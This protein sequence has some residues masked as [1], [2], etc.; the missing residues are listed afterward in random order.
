M[1]HLKLQDAFLC[2]DCETIGSDPRE[3]IVCLSHAVH[4]VAGFLNRPDYVHTG[5]TILDLMTLAEHVI[6]QPGDELPLGWMPEI[7]DGRG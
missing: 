6:P 4:S 1:P 7:E 2:I 3:C 5:K